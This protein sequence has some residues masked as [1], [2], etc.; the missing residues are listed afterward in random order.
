MPN[1]HEDHEVERYAYHDGALSYTPR[2][3]YVWSGGG[4]S[5]AQMSSPVTPTAGG[6]IDGVSSI[7]GYGN[8]RIF[9]AAVPGVPIKIEAA[10]AFSIG[11]SL[12]TTSNGRVQTQAAGK[13][14]LRALEAA[15]G[16]G[17][18]VLAVFLSGPRDGD[19]DNGDKSSNFTVDWSNGPNQRVRLT[20][21][22]TIFFSNAKP[23]GRYYLRIVQDGTGSRTP[24]L[25]GVTYPGGT[26]PTWTITASRQD[27]LA[28]YS[29]NGS[30]LFV[31]TFGLN[32]NS[33]T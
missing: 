8:G 22:I 1:L 23:G 15:S 2:R 21:S 25:S 13:A 28:I 7:D 17:S 18:I 20:A 11:A 6:D 32:F 27:I 9:I 5:P 30:V 14:V 12:E 33:T 26:A 3:C 29:P 4:G 10:A 19:F 24:T 31:S 16:A